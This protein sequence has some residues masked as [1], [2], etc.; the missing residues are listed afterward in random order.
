[1]V[2]VLGMYEETDD[3]FGQFD[4]D[5]NATDEEEY[6][7]VWRRKVDDEGSDEADEEERVE[8]RPYLI[9][10]VGCHRVR[11]FLSVRLTGRR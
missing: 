8:K 11:I 3:V 7:A 10:L 1:M 6:S 4:N 2:L 5:G 9:L